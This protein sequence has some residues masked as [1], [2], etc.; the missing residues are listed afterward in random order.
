MLV[1]RIL[2]TNISNFHN[3]I[4]CKKCETAVEV[5]NKFDVETNEYTV[6]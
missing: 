3:T 6:Y 1:R 4:E 2:F 5:E